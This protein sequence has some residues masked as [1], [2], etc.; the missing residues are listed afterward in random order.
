MYSRKNEFPKIFFP[1]CI[2]F[3]PGG[4]DLRHTRVNL[5]KVPV[6]RQ[7]FCEDIFLMPETQA[8]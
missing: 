1:V 3:V 4:N 7:G 6:F 5:E 8:S 2:G